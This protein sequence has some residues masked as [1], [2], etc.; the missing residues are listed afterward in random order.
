MSFGGGKHN[1]RHEGIVLPDGA[2]LG[3]GGGGEVGG[4]SGGEG[5]GREIARIR[6]GLGKKEI[7]RQGPSHGRFMVGTR[8]ERKKK[9][10][11]IE[12]MNRGVE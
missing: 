4:G 12:S 6:K 9:K 3:G 2:G 1:S 7:S 5:S 8:S 10:D 11:W